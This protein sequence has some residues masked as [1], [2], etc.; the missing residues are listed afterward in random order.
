MSVDPIA[1]EA[2]DAV[3]G[4]AVCYNPKAA[5]PQLAVARTSAL[6]AEEV[7]TPQLRETAEQRAD[8]R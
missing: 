6:E 3:I 1:E 8:A 5:I 7:L 2:Q 4:W